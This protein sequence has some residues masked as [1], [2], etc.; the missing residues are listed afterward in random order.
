MSSRK[1][2]LLW[3]GLLVV[4]AAVGLASVQL[5]S[6]R[7]HNINVNTVRQVRTGMTVAEVE[8]LL[9]ASPGDHGRG[10][11]VLVRTPDAGTL[12]LLVPLANI[13]PASRPA[14]RIYAG[15]DAGVVVWLDPDQR[16]TRVQIQLLT[17]EPESV[18]ARVR[19]WV[20]L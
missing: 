11:V 7:R 20:G 9:G 16:V 2:V 4:L 1:R 13:D 5:L 14:T 19:R 12:P 8:T 10:E 17:R 6:A 15:E 18:L 3:A